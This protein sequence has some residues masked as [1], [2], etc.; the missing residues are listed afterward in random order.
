MPPPCWRAV[1]EGGLIDRMLAPAG[2]DRLP[3]V[4]GFGG[5]FAVLT[6]LSYPYVYLPVVARLASLP[7]SLEESA[8]LL[9]RRPAQVF[10]SVVLPQ[11][12]P[13]VAAGALLVCLYTVSDFGAVALMRYDTLTRGIYEN[14]L[15]DQALS[16]ALGLVLAAVAVA[17]VAAERAAARSVPGVEVSR[18]RRSHR[19]ALGRLRWP[20]LGA[21][22]AVVTA[23]L[24]GPLATL[25]WW[26]IRGASNDAF[27][28][29]GGDG[30][31]SPTITSITTGV[32]AAVVTVA[33]VLPVAYL[34]SRYR[35]RAGALANALVIGGFALPGLVIALALALFTVRSSVLNGLY[36]TTT[37]LTLAYAVHFGGQALRAS[38]VAVGGVPAGLVD[39]ARVL[40][41]GRVRRFLTV[42]TPLMAPGLAA[43]AGLV[44]LSTMKELPATLLLSPPGFRTLATE[45]WQAAETGALSRAGV[46]SLI[47]VAA[48][49]VP[50]W[51]L[52]IRNV[53]RTGP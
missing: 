50:T 2:L 13:A 4:R 24:L 21:V 3:E 9:G 11:A 51:L 48:S 8:R 17:L 47:L 23:A 42:E 22:A 25:G 36:Q 5:A 30:L 33:V 1:S 40:G 6:L 45:I 32:I 38:Q 53:D 31:V 12:A 44:L 26:A 20:A 34:T 14:R 27:T 15:F 39:A 49:A 10:W 18:A 35:S 46:A 7:P 29:S 43:G 37:L 41:A 16:V 52:V 28:V 19:V